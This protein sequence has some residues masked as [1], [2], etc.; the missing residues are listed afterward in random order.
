MRTRVFRNQEGASPGGGAPAAPAE[1]DA[2][3]GTAAPAAP[4]L[5]PDLLKSMIAEAVAGIGTEVKN[6]VFA[7]LRRAGALKQDKPA[8]TPTSEPA[9]PSPSAPQAGISAADMK[10]FVE[11]TRTIERMAAKNEWTDAQLRRAESAMASVPIESLAQ[12]L[13]SFATEMNLVKSEQ[14]PQPVNST[15]VTQQLPASTGQPISD[16]GSPAPG[17]VL[18]WE[19]EFA[20]KPHA[21]SKAARDRMDAKLGVDK[22]RAE[23]VRATMERFGDM[24]VTFPK[25]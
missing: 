20:D 18:D 8:S 24:R 7:E 17:G 10:A 21:M 25:G 1:P 5:T 15:N 4:A 9:P 13:T 22:A 16:K 23:R 2:S 12:E 19:R 14:K 11:R 3:T 6:G